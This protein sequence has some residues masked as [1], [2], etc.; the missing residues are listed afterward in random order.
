MIEHSEASHSNHITLL[1]HKVYVYVQDEESSEVPPAKT[2]SVTA[3]IRAGVRPQLAAAICE[4]P[5]DPLLD[6]SDPQEAQLLQPFLLAWAVLLAHILG[7]PAGDSGK[8]FLA[9]AL[10]DEYE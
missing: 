8:A 9:Q 7:M 5:A 2:D 10:R 1:V 3:L 4:P 6:L